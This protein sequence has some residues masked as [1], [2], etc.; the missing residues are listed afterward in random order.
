M[1]TAT[2]YLAL[3]PWEALIEIINQKY[4]LELDSATTKLVQFT[5]EGGTRTAIRLAAHRSAR[6]GNLLPPSF[7]RTFHYERIDLMAYFGTTPIEIPNLRAPVSTHTLIERLSTQTGV[8]FDRND[9]VNEII[10]SDAELADYTLL[11]NPRSLR[12][13]GQVRLT[14]TAPK[15]TLTSLSTVN[16]PGSLPLSQP[17]PN[18]W[19]GPYLLMPYDFTAYRDELRAIEPNNLTLAPERL[20]AILTQV[21]PDLGPW[22]CQGLYVPWNVGYD[23]VGD[24]VWYRVAYNG[25]TNNRWTPCTEKRRVLVLELNTQLCSNGGGRLLLHYD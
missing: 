1:L 12:W 20:I 6:A 7:E 22:V 17:E 2:D 5:P 11:A 24:V 8:V 14:G 25:R 16:Y 18:R 21:T 15:I 10:T 3:D 13:V 23:V 9:F 4:F 19:E